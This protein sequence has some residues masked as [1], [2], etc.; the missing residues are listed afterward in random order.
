MDTPLNPLTAVA[1]EPPL[2]NWEEFRANLESA[3]DASL[4]TKAKP[5]NHVSVLIVVWEASSEEFKKEALDMKR[6]FEGDFGYEIELWEIPIK[7][8]ATGSS[9][10]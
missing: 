2:A 3:V 8:T 5:Y 4:P 1:N 7:R 10:L 9:I 6:F